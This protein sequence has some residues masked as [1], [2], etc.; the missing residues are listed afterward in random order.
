MIL[1][2]TEKVEKIISA[3]QVGDIVDLDAADDETKA[4]NDVVINE[5]HGEAVSSV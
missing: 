5:K 2:L 4:C 3:D 1:S